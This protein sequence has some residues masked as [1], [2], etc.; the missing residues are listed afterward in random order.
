MDRRPRSRGVSHGIPTACRR[1]WW[2]DLPSERS[3]VTNSRRLQT[4]SSVRLVV[5]TSSCSLTALD[6]T[7][8]NV[9]LNHR[10]ECFLA[11]FNKSNFAG[12]SSHFEHTTLSGPD[13]FLDRTNSSS[14]GEYLDR[15]LGQN[16]QPFSS[17]LLQHEHTD[18][19]R[20]MILGLQLN[21][22]KRIRNM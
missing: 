12:S 3:I 6:T 19:N 16:I 20:V 5:G 17:K 22:S 14:C 11:S 4:L 7:P 10:V 13:G 15:S 18:I 1:R 2:S 9:K 21:G 8:A